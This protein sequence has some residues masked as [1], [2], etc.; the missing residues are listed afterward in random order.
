MRLIF[1][2]FFEKMAGNWG[3]PVAIRIR[4]PND[5]EPAQEPPI[6]AVRLGVFG[7]VSGHCVLLIQEVWSIPVPM[8]FPSPHQ[9]HGESR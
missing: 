2:C 9:L 3:L 4:C 6:P 7:I 8:A 5:F 1:W